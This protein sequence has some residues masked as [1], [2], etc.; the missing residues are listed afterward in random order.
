VIILTKDQNLELVLE[1]RKGSH[2]F[3]KTLPLVDVQH[4]LSRLGSSLQ[5]IRGHHVPVVKHAL[6]E[7]LTRGRSP[8]CAREPKG[9]DDREVSL[10]VVE[11]GTRPLSPQTRAPSEHH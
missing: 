3:L 6:R 1:L 9:L 11:W 5:R 10:D 4:Q 7:C 8:Q 2:L